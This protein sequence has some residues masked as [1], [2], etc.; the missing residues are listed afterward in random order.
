MDFGANMKLGV[1][2]EDTWD[3]FHD[4]YAE[5]QAHHDVTLFERRNF[6]LPVF[7]Q[8]INHAQFNRGLA[9][10]LKANDVVFFEWSSELLAAASHMPKTCRI[11]T[12]LH[13]FEMYQWLDKI[14]WNH[15]DKLIVVSHAKR[16]EF[17][18]RFPAQAHIVE[19]I[20]EAIDL[21]KFQFQPKPFSGNL[22]ILCHL[23]P[24]KRVYETILDF[25][26]LSKQRDDL[27]L[28]IGGG[29]AEGFHEYPIALY[30]LV[31]K[32]DL[33]ERITFYGNVSDNK[34]WYENIDIFISNGYSEGWQVSLIE[35]MA[36]GCFCLAHQWAG[37]DEYLPAVHLYFTGTEFQQRVLTYCDW[38]ADEKQ[39]QLVCQRQIVAENFDMAQTKVRIRELVE[40]V[41]AAI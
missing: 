31:A 22:G 28:H 19:V 40:K 18:A 9:A 11:V 29:G 21:E 16:D 33:G 32:L 3:F 24:R 12:R 7:N 23:R 37:A 20:T 17:A 4:I 27:H 13:R 25:Y 10:F 2:I 30:Q 38:T 36:S 8:R 15:V 6:T 1:A 39:Q 34:A 35:A 5:F 41:G 14:N 26:E